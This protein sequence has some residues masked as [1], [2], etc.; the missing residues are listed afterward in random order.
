MM[1]K[2]KMSENSL[3]NLEKGKP[4]NSNSE[5]IAR[6]AQ[7]KSVEKRKE[8]KTL[9]EVASEKLL[10]RIRDKTFQEI[11]IDELLNYVFSES[12]KPEIII[13]ILEFLR[14]TSGQKP[15]DI[16]ENI[17]LNTE[18]KAIDRKTISEAIKKIK[19]LQE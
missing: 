8:N 11:A 16:A 17:N 15:K 12:A 18:V 1:A 9:R 13:K 14:D 5:E 7:E 2:R 6:K 4:F 3:K 10:K 19:E